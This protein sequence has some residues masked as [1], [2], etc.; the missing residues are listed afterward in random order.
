MHFIIAP[1]LLGTLMLI[2]GMGLYELF[3]SNLDIV[4]SLLDANLSGL[5]PSLVIFS[6]LWSLMLSINHVLKRRFWLHGKIDWLKNT[7]RVPLLWKRK[8][9]LLKTFKK[10][11]FRQ[12]VCENQFGKRCLV[13]KHSLGDCSSF[14]VL[15]IFVNFVL[16]ERPRW[17]E[18][19]SVSD[20][21]TM[22][23]HVIV[24]FL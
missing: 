11:S 9:S 21:K 19:K 20:L 6:I 23:W 13:T 4:K 22:V 10:T 18:I 14:P 15:N 1:D 3:V 8:T 16:R 17:L 7:I 12:P 24:M 2:F 5:F